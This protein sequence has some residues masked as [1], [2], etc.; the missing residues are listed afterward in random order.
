MSIVRWRLAEYLEERNFT[1]Y[2]LVQ[3]IGTTRMNTIYRIARRGDE[4]TRVDLPTL[5]SVLDG[6]RK[7]TGQDVAITDVLEYI[8]DPESPTG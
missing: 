3:A 4:P 7:L 2:A 8:P 5:A 6:L 1:T